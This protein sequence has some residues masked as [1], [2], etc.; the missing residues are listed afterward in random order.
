MMDDCRK[1][2]VLGDFLFFFFHVYWL[3][4][5]KRMCL[6]ISELKK[7]KVLENALL[8]TYEKYRNVKKY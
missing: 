7:K 3:G 6:D 5:K 4:I 1:K 2:I 8:V